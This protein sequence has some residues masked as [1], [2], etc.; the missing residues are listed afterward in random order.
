[1]IRQR[2]YVLCSAWMLLLLVPMMASATVDRPLPSDNDEAR[3]QILFSELRCAVCEG[4]SLAASG[5]TLAIEMRNLIRDQISQG[6]S[7]NDI[8][9]YFAERYGED[10]LMHPP[11]AER[12]LLL[13]LA[14]LLF[15][16]L[17]GTGA[18]LAIRHQRRTRNS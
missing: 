5:A 8:L 17:G 16:A 9:S 1:M 13:W 3:A 12:T 15:L 18:A 10:I 4:Q 11:V 2:F 6:R 14:P 7:D